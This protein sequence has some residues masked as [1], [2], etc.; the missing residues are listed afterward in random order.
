M[1]WNRVTLSE[2]LEK[3][4]ERAVRDI[5]EKALADTETTL[6][7]IREAFSLEK[8]IV[9]L[10]EEVETAKIEKAR[11]D[12]EHARKIREVE[13]KVGLERKRQ[14]FEVDQAKRETRVEIREKNLEQERKLFEEKVAYYEKQ[15][16]KRLTDLQ[17]IIKPLLKALPS[18]EIIAKV[19]RED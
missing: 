3:K 7:K 9:K 2:R 17:E 10:R 4:I 12:E 14:E 6:S 15:S 1:F 19:N 18:A 5:V 13:H 16:E 11:H 8:Q